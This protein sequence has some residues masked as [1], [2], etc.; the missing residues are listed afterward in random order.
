VELDGPALLLLKRR[1]KG[2]IRQR[3]RA[4]RNAIPE[5][6][7]KER[8]RRI[9][10]RLLELPELERAR[11][12]GLYAPLLPR[13]EVDVSPLHAALRARGASVFYPFMGRPD[14]DAGFAEVKEPE[15][16]APRGHG[17]AE[18]PDGAR[19]ARPGELDVLVVPALAVSELGYRLGYGS[20]FYDAVL[21]RF[22]PPA[23]SIVVAYDFQLL[24]ELPTEEQ[25][26]PCGIVVTDAR[27]LRPAI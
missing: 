24:A 8:S 15:E 6:A 19:A 9:V 13:G 26:V 5:P 16:L 2:Q 20:G 21:P 22:C 11:T 4:L 23:C 10:E 17:F 3:M 27:V 1:A 25:D 14:A 7:R 18:P 12:A